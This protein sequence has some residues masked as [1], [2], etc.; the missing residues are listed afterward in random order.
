MT[1]TS[2]ATPA[3][4]PHVCVTAHVCLCLS[5]CLSL[6]LRASVTV[7]VPA[8]VR[9]ISSVRGNLIRFFR[10]PPS[11][12]DLSRQKIT[13]KC[14]V[15]WK[16][17][18][19]SKKITRQTHLFAWQRHSEPS[20]CS[21]QLGS[22]LTFRGEQTMIWLVHRS[23]VVTSG[24][25]VT[26]CNSP[27]ALLRFLIKTRYINKSTV[28]I[29]LTLQN[30]AVN[31]HRNRNY[32]LYTLKHSIVLSVFI[33]MSICTYF[34]VSTVSAILDFFYFRHSVRITNML[35]GSGIRERSQQQNFRP[36][37]GELKVNCLVVTVKIMFVVATN[38]ADW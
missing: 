27:L 38:I 35:M 3:A 6:S 19:K 7:C 33:I 21:K 22:F 15:Y 16:R 32:A 4:Q 17:W 29:T 28:R 36:Q 31:V 2:V 37:G 30:A 1:G 12:V 25:H 20:K 24:K 34:R 8:C 13:N 11:N 9:L 23:D 14:K 10:S 26:S 5:V 18:W